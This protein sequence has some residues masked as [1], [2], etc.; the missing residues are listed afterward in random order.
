MKPKH[1]FRSISLVVGVALVLCA[2]IDG[3][4]NWLPHL[5]AQWL[6]AAGVVLIALAARKSVM[7]LPK[8]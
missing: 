2:L 6:L 8:T 4:I 5:D 7:E 1:I 3:R